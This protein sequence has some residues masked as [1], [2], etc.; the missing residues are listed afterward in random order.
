[1]DG[2]GSSGFVVT[3]TLPGTAEQFVRAFDE[4]V[5][6]GRAEDCGLRLA[7]PLVSRR[8]AEIEPRSDGSFV[9]R[10]LGSRNGTRVNGALL[11]NRRT[12]VTTPFRAELGPYVVT[13]HVETGS[14]ETMVIA[15]PETE[16]TTRLRVDP[17]KR[18]AVIDGQPVGT[19][20]VLEFRLLDVLCAAGSDV[21]A[22]ATAGD[23]VWATGQ[24]D[25]YMLHN[26][27]RRVRKKLD[28]ASRG[29][30]G[31]IVSVPGTG[32]RVV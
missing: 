12:S 4:R 9:I 30:G 20:S 14:D 21:V 11:R 26:L 22:N 27:V 16:A 10:D 29:A 28:A 31:L 17:G 23:A 32:Y 2:E 13:V 5:V 24:W 6:I 1:M 7:H 25:V 8:H 15:L 19:L 3:V 18:T